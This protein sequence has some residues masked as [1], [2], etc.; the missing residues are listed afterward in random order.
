MDWV[1]QNKCSRISNKHTLFT[2]DI[3]IQLHE[4]FNCIK[5]RY[6]DIPSGDDHTKQSLSVCDEVVCVILSQHCD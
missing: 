1:L 5:H 4:T 2:K 3:P 6:N